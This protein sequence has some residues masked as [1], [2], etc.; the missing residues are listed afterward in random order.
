MGRHATAIAAD[1]ITPP[2]S[3]SGKRKRS[4]DS[5]PE[6]EVDV[7]AP[8]PP[9][10]KA[11]RKFKKAKSAIAH[12]GV[13]QENSKELPTK[14]TTEADL[15]TPGKSSKRSD[16]GIWIGNLPWTAT[17]LDLREFL[18]KDTNISDDAITR[19]HMPPP[20]KNAVASSREKIKPQNQGFA[21]VDFSTDIALAEALG[22]SERL[23]KGRRLLIKDSKSFEGRPEKQNGEG[24]PPAISGKP[25]SRRVFVGNL[26]F[27]VTKETLEEHFSRCGEISN[28]HLATFED[29][30]KCKGFGWVEFAALEAGEAAVRGWVSC[31]QKD[32]TEDEEDESAEVQTNEVEPQRRTKHRKWWVNRLGGRLLR[33]EFAEGKDVRYKKRYGKEGTARK[34][35]IPGEEMGSPLTANPDRS[36]STSAGERDREVLRTKPFGMVDARTVKPGAAL[37]AAPRLTGGIVESQGTKTVFA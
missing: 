4:Q 31:E 12:A 7:S 20:K 9:S 22:L 3:P 33:M 35:Q 6:I 17:K 21:Y 11:L 32:S 24:R 10:K 8:E 26:G 28:V 29:S 5:Q 37:A 2:A 15:E 23:I 13:E 18:T 36:K 14:S 16:Y 27:D 25:A 1:S 30:G 34:D 19:L